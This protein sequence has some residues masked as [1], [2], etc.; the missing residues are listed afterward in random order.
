MGPHA[1]GGVPDSFTVVKGGTNPPHSSGEVF[2]GSQGRTLQEAS[3]GVP[4]N[5]VQHATAGG[6]VSSA[7]EFNESVGRVNYQ[8]VDVVDG[9]L[10]TTV[11]KP[12]VKN[13]VPKPKRFGGD[14]YDY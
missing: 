7:P 3:A 8:H 2:S 4:H 6:S 12:P 10:S 14:E 9:P 13:E 1:P 11:F 5:Q